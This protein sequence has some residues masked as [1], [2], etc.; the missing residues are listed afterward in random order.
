MEEKTTSD[1]AGRT[2]RVIL[3]QGKNEWLLAGGHH[4]H[5]I[6]QSRLNIGPNISRSNFN[7]N[8]FA[9]W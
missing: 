8:V 6:D 4:V 9:S 2:V 5:S 1:P 7:K 3:G